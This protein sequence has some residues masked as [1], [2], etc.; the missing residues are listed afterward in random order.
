MTGLALSYAKDKKWDALTIS[1]SFVLTLLVPAALVFFVVAQATI[2]QYATYG[3][4]LNFPSEYESFEEIA[5]MVG[6]DTLIYS[7]RSISSQ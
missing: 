2:D 7:G 5:R 1:G 3:K 6:N 4:L